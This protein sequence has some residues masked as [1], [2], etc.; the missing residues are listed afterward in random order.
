VIEQL[1]TSPLKHSKSWL[2]FASLG[3]F[4]LPAAKY[5]RT[6]V[7]LPAPTAGLPSASRRKAVSVTLPPTWTSATSGCTSISVPGAAAE[8]V[9]T[10]RRNDQARAIEEAVAITRR[11]A[12]RAGT[13]GSLTSVSA[14]HSRR[15]ERAICFS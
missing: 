14:P 13:T 15:S 2:L 4:G 1:P 3:S 10:V 8:G 11:H 6:C 7:L 12:L 5:Q 9:T